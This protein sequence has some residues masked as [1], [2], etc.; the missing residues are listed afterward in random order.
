M[1]SSF[2]QADMD[3]QLTFFIRGPRG[4][5]KS[6]LLNAMFA[7][8][9]NAV[10]AGTTPL[11]INVTK[12]SPGKRNEHPEVLDFSF[13]ALGGLFPLVDALKYRFITTSG[14]EDD[15]ENSAHYSLFTKH[16]SAVLLVVDKDRLECL[17]SQ[18]SVLVQTVKD[19]QAAQLHAHVSVP[20]IVVVNKV[21]DADDTDV[22]DKVEA[23]RDFVSSYVK[24]QGLWSQ[25][26]EVVAM[27][28]LHSYLYRSF[29]ST[30]SFT[31]M[32]SKEV[33]RLCG[34]ELGGQGKDLAKDP[35]NYKSL[36]N[37]IRGRLQSADA[38]RRWQAHC[39]LTSLVNAVTKSVLTEKACFPL[40]QRQLSLQLDLLPPATLPSPPP[41]KPP[42][43]PSHP[44]EIPTNVTSNDDEK[45][46]ATT[47]PASH[48]SS[49]PFNNGFGLGFS[50]NPLLF[51]PNSMVRKSS[52]T[53][54]KKPLPSSAAAPVSDAI[55]T[56]SSN[57]SEAPP[58][59]AAKLTANMAFIINLHNKY[60]T[61]VSSSEANHVTGSSIE[62]VPSHPLYSADIET[63]RNNFRT[64]IQHNCTVKY[65]KNFSA[66]LKS[67]PA[68]ME[69]HEITR[70]M[71]ILC[72][73]MI[74]S[75][76]TIDVSGMRNAESWNNAR[77]KG[78]VMLLELV[79]SKKVDHG[80]FSQ[81][82]SD[83]TI[84]ANRDKIQRQVLITMQILSA[85][86]QVAATHYGMTDRLVVHLFIPFIDALPNSIATISLPS[87]N[88]QKTKDSDNCQA[89]KDCADDEDKMDTSRP[90]KTETDVDDDAVEMKFMNDLR[91]EMHSSSAVADLTAGETG[92]SND[93]K[94]E[95]NERDGKPAI[96]LVHIERCVLALIL[97]REEGGGE[98]SS[99][100]ALKLVRSLVSRKIQVRDKIMG[101][102][103]CLRE[104][105]W[106][107]S[108]ITQKSVYNSLH[109]MYFSL[110][111]PVIHCPLPQID[112]MWGMALASNV[113]YDK[114]I[115]QFPYLDSERELILRAMLSD[116]VD[117]ASSL[118]RTPSSK[119]AR[120][121]R[122][123]G[124][125]GRG[126]SS[127]NS[128]NS[129]ISGT[130]TGASS[131]DDC[132]RKRKEKRH[133]SRAPPQEQAQVLPDADDM[134]EGRVKRNRRD[135]E[136]SQAGMTTPQKTVDPSSS[137]PASRT[138]TRSA[139]KSTPSRMRIIRKSG[140]C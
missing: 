115:A 35:N 19:L 129:D 104:M 58:Q 15:P 39:G 31:L 120:P 9:I 26:V 16:S 10:W 127:H 113:D 51:S 114:E 37:E 6:S 18:Q 128:V 90:E 28:S 41:P 8:G 108:D 4:S 88:Y 91:Q 73:D 12:E 121:P 48:F 42:R 140:E 97:G 86:C 93:S 3:P 82:L 25:P 139:A 29:L 59:D 84:A 103:T 76:E 64:G 77:T 36:E 118:N 132:G 33:I 138:S 102:T 92:S 45:M 47:P 61:L 131:V 66:Y 53:T 2:T 40:L 78:I 71:A 94:N 135:D 87:Y 24:Q 13:G 57:T 49:S 34:M 137:T 111:F 79:W 101:Y 69:E 20:L 70:D 74:D 98:E 80:F 30:S 63:V 17:P 14:D 107:H 89:N 56:V 52:T 67:L 116:D 50:M 7:Q 75:H 109:R 126:A 85:S 54:L 32:A 43:Q 136:E 123:A 5:G 21:D 46:S 27:S 23:F 11:T 55:V 105:L 106:A 99:Q 1:I 65:R 117:T 133:I 44:L 60:A 130:G 119:R 124:S 22:L 125:R 81:V 72:L 112:E 38:Q 68:Y 96:V 95:P 122:I 110:F 100:A 62:S 134:Q 83:S